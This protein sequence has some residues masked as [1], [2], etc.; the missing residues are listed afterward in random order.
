[1][2]STGTLLIMESMTTRQLAGSIVSDEIARQHMSGA[3]AAKAWHIA[4]STLSKVQ[5]GDATVTDYTLRGIEGGLDLP[6]R[7]LSY[8]I[9]GDIERISRQPGLRESLRQFTIEALEDIRRPPN[10]R[11]VDK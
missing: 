11:A 4:R 7:F 5:A 8:V 3:S 1:M 9:N 2:G 6:D 10:R